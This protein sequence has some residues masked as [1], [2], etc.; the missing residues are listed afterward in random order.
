MKTRSTLL[1]ATCLLLLLLFSCKQKWDYSGEISRLDSAATELIEAKKH[2]LSVDT[3]AVR[4]KF[5]F[6]KE[7]IHSISENISKDTIRKEM[8]LF[9]SATYE[10]IGDMQNL[11]ENKKY[12]ERALDETR[13]RI[14]DLQHDLKEGLVEK[15]KAAEY[16]AAE[17]NTSE[18]LSGTITT[19]V[20]KA[21]TS[22]TKLDSLSDRLLFLA[23]SLTKK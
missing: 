21:K 12:L 11:L 9:L 8:A 2:F 22:F 1:P 13:Q 18:K 20:N 14:S 7:K 4:A 5:L 19:A 23:D 17:I 3:I 6:A 16:I 10:E 15:E